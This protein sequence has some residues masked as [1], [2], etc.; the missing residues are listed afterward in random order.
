[1]NWKSAFRFWLIWIIPYLA[2]EC[3]S[4][5]DNSFFRL[6]ILTVTMILFWFLFDHW[7]IDRKK[8]DE[9]TNIIN[10]GLEDIKNKMMEKQS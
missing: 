6:I 1:M 3:V 2:N 7:F 4:E 9:Y 8:V 10:Q 5:I